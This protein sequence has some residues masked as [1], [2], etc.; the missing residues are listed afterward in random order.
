M[1]V[2]IKFVCNGFELLIERGG[3]LCN[4]DISSAE[5]AFTCH[6]LVPWAGD[7]TGSC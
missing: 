2:D 1:F 6:N 5:Y 3:S 7:I 4:P